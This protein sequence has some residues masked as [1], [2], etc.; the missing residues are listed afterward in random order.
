MENR[1]LKVEQKEAKR[2]YFELLPRR[3][4]SRLEIKKITKEMKEKKTQEEM[5]KQ[6]RINASSEER[7]LNTQK[8]AMML[9]REQ[10][11]M[12]RA[13]EKEKY[14]EEDE[15]EKL[16]EAMKG[17]LYKM[18]NS[19]NDTKLKALGINSELFNKCDNNKKN[20]MIVE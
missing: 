12:R 8:R 18:K 11:R 15:K 13:Q 3:V 19:Q 17:S 4:S 5:E 9:E 6:S 7:L 14:L 2:R 20:D 16:Y 1:K 10:R